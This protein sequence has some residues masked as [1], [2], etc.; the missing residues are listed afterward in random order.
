MRGPEGHEKRPPGLI[1]KVFLKPPSF[2]GGGW[3]SWLVFH[4]PL[5]PL[6]LPRVKRCNQGEGEALGLLCFRN[7]KFFLFMLAALSQ[8]PEVV[9]CNGAPGEL[10]LST[11]HVPTVP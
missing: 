6:A 7:A 2:G 1:Q 9:C 4:S 3:V 5:N 11:S 8:S 10:P